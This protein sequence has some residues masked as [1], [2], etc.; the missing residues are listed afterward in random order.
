MTQLETLT[1]DKQSN[2]LGQ[3]LSYEKNEVLWIHTQGPCS[4][5]FIFFITYEQA[6]KAR[7]FYNTTWNTYQGQTL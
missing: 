4:Q 5:L 2:L 6:Q 1:R 7:L 3:F